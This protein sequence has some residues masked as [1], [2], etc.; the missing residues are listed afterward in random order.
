MAG[1]IDGIGL[2]SGGLGIIGF[3]QDN[4]PGPAIPE[5]PILRIKVGLEKGDDEGQL[6]CPSTQLLRDP[7]AFS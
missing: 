3:I 2:L 4:I 1:L 6:V 5:G 7:D